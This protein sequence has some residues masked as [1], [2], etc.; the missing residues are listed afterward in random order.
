MT[1]TRNGLV[2]VTGNGKTDGPVLGTDAPA[3]QW[4]TQQGALVVVFTALSVLVIL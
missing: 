4:D 3:G 1:S 2:R